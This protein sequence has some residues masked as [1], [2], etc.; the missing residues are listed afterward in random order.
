MAFLEWVSK[1]IAPASWSVAENQLEMERHDL[2]NRINHSQRDFD[3]YWK[4][5]TM[6][7]SIRIW[8]EK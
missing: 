5:L 7:T 6:P 3:I 8:G 2:M 4:N 1:L